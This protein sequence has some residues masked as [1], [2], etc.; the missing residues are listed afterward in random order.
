MEDPM[1]KIVREA[2]VGSTLMFVEEEDRRDPPA[3]TR[4]GPLICE[5]CGDTLTAEERHYY[6]YRCEGCETE[7]SNTMT[8]WRRGEDNLALDVLYSVPKPVL[9]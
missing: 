8:R 9:H 6:E 1:E 5:D 4:Y 3:M 7:W 2:L